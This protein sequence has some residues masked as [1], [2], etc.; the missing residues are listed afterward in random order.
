MSQSSIKKS[1]PVSSNILIEYVAKTTI[2]R[3]KTILS[4]IFCKRA[5][6]RIIFLIIN[7]IEKD[8]R[9]PF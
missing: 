3:F 1:L 2:Y 6:K 5:L 4:T 8:V 7:I 9:H